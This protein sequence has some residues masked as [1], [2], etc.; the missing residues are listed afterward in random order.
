MAIIEP[1]TKVD[2]LS[3]QVLTSRNIRGGWAM[4]L[5]MGGLNYQVEHHL[6]PNMS[7]PSLGRTRAIV[8]EYCENIG[9][10]YTETSLVES[11]AIVIRYLNTVGLA[12]RDPFDCPERVAMGR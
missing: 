1:G 12:A 8:K 2:F 9:L 11:Y 4:S 10:K 7:R 3:K 6:F 5:L